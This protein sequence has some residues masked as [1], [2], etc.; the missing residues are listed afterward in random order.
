MGLRHA[1]S[2]GFISLCAL[3]LI[4]PLCLAEI[5]VLYDYW[6]ILKADCD[7]M[8]EAIHSNYI[9]LPLVSSFPLFA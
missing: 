1:C 4:V 3:D 5:I 7:A 8:E 2:I 6:R 9:L